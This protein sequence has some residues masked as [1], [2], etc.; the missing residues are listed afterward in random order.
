MGQLE[1][2]KE[3]L[4]RWAVPLLVLIVGLSYALAYNTGGWRVLEIGVAFAVS[5]PLVFRAQAP[6][7]VF[8]IVLVGAGVQAAFS[9]SPQEAIPLSMWLA[10]GAVGRHAEEPIA[11]VAPLTVV[12]I[13]VGIAALGAAPLVDMLYMAVVMVG[14]WFLGRSFRLRAKVKAHQ[15]EQ[16]A[17][18]IEQAEARETQAAETER[19]RIARELHDIVGHATSLITIR[20]QALR[21]SLP[22]DDPTTNEIRSIEGEARQALSDMRRLVAVMRAPDGESRL[23]PTPGL[24]D[25]PHLMDGMRRAG[26]TVHADIGQIPAH[27]DPGVQL[28]AYR[29][30]Q[31]ALTNTIRHADGSRVEISIAVNNDEL[32]IDVNDDGHRTPTEHNGSGLFGMRQRVALYD[33]KVS[34]GPEPDGGYRVRALLRIPEPSR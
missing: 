21:R 22:P 14:F 9:S 6:I 1:A 33:G 15:Q 3:A 4:W 10:S 25:L 31:E 13:S 32:Q 23:E 28:A 20:L 2:L 34:A 29:V 16:A 18:L 24:S 8:C 26:Y 30:V 12:A 17:L 7:F 5:V 11:W 27:L 19:A